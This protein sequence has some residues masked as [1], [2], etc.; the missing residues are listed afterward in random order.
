MYIYINPGLACLENSLEV[1][2][3]EL[4]SIHQ[5]LESRYFPNLCVIFG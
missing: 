5:L 4:K 2:F 1:P 3:L